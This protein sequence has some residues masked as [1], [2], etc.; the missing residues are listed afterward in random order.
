MTA[1]TVVIFETGLLP[2]IAAGLPHMT[3]ARRM[4]ATCG[5]GVAGKLGK[6]EG[7]AKG[8][9][10]QDARMRPSRN[11]FVALH[12]DAPVRLGVVVV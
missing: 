8:G 4:E 2:G 5:Q 10:I 11:V 12:G 7:G 6:G 3:G 1:V 9:R